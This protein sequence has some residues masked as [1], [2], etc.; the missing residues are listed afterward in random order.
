MS[1][2][3]WDTYILAGLLGLY[4]GWS[5]NSSLRCTACTVCPSPVLRGW[6]LDS[7]GPATALT[8]PSIEKVLWEV[9]YQSSWDTA[10]SPWVIVFCLDPLIRNAPMTM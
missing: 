8:M 10:W 9:V 7:L 1:W 2:W 6:L 3:L 4:G 5:C